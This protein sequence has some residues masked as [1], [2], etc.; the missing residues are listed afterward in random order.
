MIFKIYRISFLAGL[1]LKEIKDSS[2][3]EFQD[4]FSQI[5]AED[6]QIIL[7][8]FKLEKPKLENGET[9]GT[10]FIIFCS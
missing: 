6:Y 5:R 1:F 7:E 9:R 3:N 2:H 8:T 10:N 4:W